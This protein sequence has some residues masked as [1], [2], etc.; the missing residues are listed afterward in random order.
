M[1][2]IRLEEVAVGYEGVN[3]VEHVSFEIRRGE[4]LAILG[5]NGSGKTS[6]MKAML[7]LVRVKAGRIRLGDGLTREG[8]G[9]LPQSQPAQRDFPA[10]VEEVVQSGL[11]N[12]MGLFPRLRAEHRRRAE[13]MMAFLN[14]E[15]LR[16]KPYR[17]LSGGQ[18]QKV[19]LARALC[20]S[21]MLLMLDEPVTALDPEAT[22]EFYGLIRQLNR[23]RGM[24]M[25]MIS[26]DIEPAI[27][28]A[29]R[30]LVLDRQ[31]R[32]SG[33]VEQYRDLR[34]END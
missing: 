30:V 2:L 32:F 14:I 31:V 17:T 20:A 15:G 33:S 1:A 25:A 13:E 16:K 29:D 9:Y 7:G 22:E 28:D 12:Q 24:A 10:S 5:R 4:Y 8:I 6:L 23:E 26:H 11:L 19:L 21:D 18:R 34:L 27:R 3:V